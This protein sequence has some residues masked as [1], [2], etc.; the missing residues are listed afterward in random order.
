MPDF[1]MY[2]MTKAIPHIRINQYPTAK[3]LYEL[4][5]KD[6]QQVQ[7]RDKK[8]LDIFTNLIDQEVRKINDQI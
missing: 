4:F 7:I 8:Y 6:I 2:F 5:Y 1:S 3:E